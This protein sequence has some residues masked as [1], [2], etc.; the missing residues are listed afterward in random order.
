[1]AVAEAPTFVPTLLINIEYPEIAIARV[2]KHSDP[3]LAAKGAL[4]TDGTAI[5]FQNTQFLAQTKED[6][7]I[8]KKTQPWV[9]EEPHDDTLPFRI[10]QKTGFQTR[11]I[12]AY[13]AWLDSDWRAQI[14]AGLEEG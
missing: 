13:A 4:V 10:D 3:V 6:Y 1:M 5:K 14:V 2:R 11:N 8:V 12:D 9:F 7:D